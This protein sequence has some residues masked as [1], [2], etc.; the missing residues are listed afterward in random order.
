MSLVLAARRKAGR[1]PGRAGTQIRVNR[2][3][4]GCQTN[5]LVNS[6][7]RARQS[8]SGDSVTRISIADC[9][10]ENALYR[11]V[12]YLGPDP[13]RSIA[14]RSVRRATESVYAIGSLSGYESYSMK[15][16]K[17]RLPTKFEFAINLE[18]A[19]QIGLTIPPSVLARADR[20]IR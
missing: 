14:I 19:K 4:Q 6:R 16:S 7:E 17:R 11:L 12:V 5:W 15:I 9:P 20:G 10:L 18:T 1:S 2:E 13:K 3:S 8:E